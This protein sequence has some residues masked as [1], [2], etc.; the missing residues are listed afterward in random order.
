MTHVVERARGAAE[1]AIFLRVAGPDATATRARIHQTPGPRWFER[2]SPVQRVHGDASMF[3]GGLRALLLQSL[4]P[5]AMAG[6]AAHSGY[7]GDPWGRLQRTSTFIAVTTF[8]TA[9]DAERAVAAV[10]AVHE[11]V[12]GRAPDGRAYRASDP[13]LLRWV[14]VAETQSFLVAHQTFGRHPLDAQGCDEYVAQAAVVGRALGVVDAPLTRRELDAAVE[15]YRPTLSLTPSAL[16]A[17]RFLLVEPPL[18]WPVRPAYAGLAVAARESLPAWARAG[19]PRV[20]GLPA[21]WARPAG[22]TVT[23]LIRWALPAP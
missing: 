17:A 7:R 14:H 4:H 12:R 22:A 23:R 9:D 3:V 1:R 18:P 5:L 13:E 11:R 21:R 16:D 8:G 2:G 6:V 20:R 15:E 10:R 19:M